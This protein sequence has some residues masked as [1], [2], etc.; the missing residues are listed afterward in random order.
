MDQR[1]AISLPL[2]RPVLPA[3]GLGLV[4]L[5]WVTL[6]AS[7]LTGIAPLLHHHALIEDGPPVPVALAAFVI[8]WLVMVV[9]MMLP[10]SLPTARVMAAVMATGRR[11]WLSTAAFASVFAA[12]WVAFGIV[13]FAGDAVLHRIVD[14]TPWLASRPYLVEAGVFVLAGAYQWTPLKRRFLVACRHPA[15]FASIEDRSAFAVARTGLRH[16]LDCLGSSWALMLLMFAEGVANLWWMAA[17]TAIMTYET[18]GR[19]GARLATWA[20]FALV[21]LGVAALS[22]SAPTGLAA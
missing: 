10:A 14:A 17:L 20:G 13:A 16:G 1:L 12:V 22:P 11:P 6:A 4:A 18:T 19:R 8:G 21:F 2:S 5:A 7:Q 9:A 15:A 3:V